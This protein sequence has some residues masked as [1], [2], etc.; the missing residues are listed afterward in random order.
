MTQ[1]IDIRES[2]EAANEKFMAAFKRGD[3]AGLAALYTED[4]QVLPPN[5]DFVSGQQAVAGFW[6]VIF[7]M[8]IKEAELDIVE[9]EK[10]DDAAFEVSRFKL[11]GADGQVLD[12]GKY[13]VIWKKDHGQWKLHRDIFNSSLPAQT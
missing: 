5:G 11:L 8:G 1:S 10:Q 13:I 9:V 2:I 12:E 6:Q 7:D 3:A 4:G